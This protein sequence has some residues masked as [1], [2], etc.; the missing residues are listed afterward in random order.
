MS[1]SNKIKAFLK[2]RGVKAKDY[3]IKLNLSSPSVLDNKYRRQ[4][5]TAQDLIKLA[6]LTGTRLAFI[7]TNDKPVIVFDNEDLEDNKKKPRN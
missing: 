3:S 2:L 4:S 7:D 5:F 1:L 6:D